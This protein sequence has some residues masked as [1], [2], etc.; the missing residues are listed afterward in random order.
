VK[1]TALQLG[2]VALHDIQ[3]RNGLD[4]FHSPGY[5]KNGPVGKN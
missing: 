2:L 1:K 3:P 5:S 4:L